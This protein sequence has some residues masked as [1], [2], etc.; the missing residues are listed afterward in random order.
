MRLPLRFSLEIAA[1]GLIAVTAL[2]IGTGM[3]SVHKLAIATS[4]TALLIGGLSLAT[5]KSGLLKLKIGELQAEL[6]AVQKKLD[7]EYDDKKEL[8][9]TSIELQNKLE[10]LKLKLENIVKERDTWMIASNEAGKKIIELQQGLNTYRDEIARRDSSDRREIHIAVKEQVERIR[11]RL[12]ENSTR[13]TAEEVATKQKEFDGQLALYQGR[14]TELN[15]ELDSL[16]TELE[17]VESDNKQLKVALE[18]LHKEDLPEIQKTFESEWKNNDELMQR[19]IEQ[20]RQMNAELSKPDLFLGKTISNTRANEVIDYFWKQDI[21]LEGRWIERGESTDVIYFH[22]REL[23]SNP[24]LLETLNDVTNINWIRQ[25]FGLF[26]NPKFDIDWQRL[27]VT[28]KVVH[29]KIKASQKDVERLWKSKEEFLD[30]A[31]KWQ[32]IRITGGSESGKSPT[33][34]NVAYA[35]VSARYGQVKLY[36]PQSASAKN[37]WSIK[38]VGVT[39]KDSV[40]GMKELASLMNANTIDNSVYLFD[41]VDSTLS[42]E[43]FAAKHIKDFIK[44]ASHKTLRCLLIG[45]NANASNYKGFQRTDFNNVVNL[46]IGAN[47]YEAIEN[48]SM[49]SSQK[50]KLKGIAEKLTEYCASINQQLPLENLDSKAARFALVIEPSKQPYYLELPYFGEYKLSEIATQ[51]TENDDAASLAAN[52]ADAADKALNADS[53]VA[54]SLPVNPYIGMQCLSCNEGKYTKTKSS[55]GIKYYTCNTCHKSKS[56][57]VLSNIGS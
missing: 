34:E 35:M 15:I 48:S 7:R 47:A 11:A 12:H 20:L 43:P 26:E 2:Y 38:P 1:S 33:A 13:W 50:D 16:K 30:I 6:E 23:S 49:T 3:N 42:D 32:R 29:T 22:A 28:L 19:N 45:Q 5:D 18:S 14:V 24:D 39:H 40:S 57:N 9:S 21:T 36:D 44:Q 8:V 56:E 31:G 46:H 27:L 54:A 41:E 25:Q 37:H 53:T 51:H 4:G 10:K 55:R 52:A 17:E